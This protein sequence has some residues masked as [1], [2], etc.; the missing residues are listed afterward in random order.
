MFPICTYSSSAHNSSFCM[1]AKKEHSALIRTTSKSI[2][3]IWTHLTHWLGYIAA[4][5]RHFYPLKE[6]PKGL[7]SLGLF[8]YLFISSGSLK[9]W[10]NTTHAFKQTK[11]DKFYCKFT[12]KTQVQQ[13]NLFSAGYFQGKIYQNK[14]EDMN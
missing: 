2:K 12:Y 6:I 4:A 13:H 11:G 9:P 10:I 8:I 1:Q 3:S 7:L 5:C 14:Q